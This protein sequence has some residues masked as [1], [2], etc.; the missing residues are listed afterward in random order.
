MW[1][2]RVVREGILNRASLPSATRGGPRVSL[3]WCFPLAQPGSSG[4]SE[5]LTPMVQLLL[6]FCCCCGVQGSGAR[7]IPRNGLKALELVFIPRPDRL[8]P[9]CSCSPFF[10]EELLGSSSHQIKVTGR[11]LLEGR[12]V[13]V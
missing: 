1:R 5:G 7:D 2:W 6:L 11:G 4:C 3:S 9:L 12:D 8:S 10:S 13:P